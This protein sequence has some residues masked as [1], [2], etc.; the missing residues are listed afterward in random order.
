[1]KLVEVV[2]LVGTHCVSPVQ[3]TSLA[4]E[5]NKVSC[6][7]VVERDTI[8]GTL[9]VT[10]RTGAG[11]PMVQAAVGR[12]MATAISLPEASEPKAVADMTVI[13]PPPAPMKIE[14][15]AA[16]PSQG[17]I[18]AIARK[19]DPAIVAP[20]RSA[21][22]AA[23]PKLGSSAVT[24]VEASVEATSPPGNAV[25]TPDEVEAPK[26]NAPSRVAMA[27]KEPRVTTKKYADQCRGST[28]PV[29]Y[30]NKEGRRKYRCLRSKNTPLY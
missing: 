12:L 5:A 9:H 1:M 3:H 26:P 22:Q 6:A 21:M 4:T 14:P 18:A 20:P 27:V 7:V 11:D 30:T 19:H 29:W 17:S 28:K 23:A 8:A 15:V 16:P 2:I 24:A 25:E 10:P 13:R